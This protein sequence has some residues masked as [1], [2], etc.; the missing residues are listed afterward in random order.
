VFLAFLQIQISAALLAF[1][2][3]PRMAVRPVDP[4]P[5]PSPHR[6]LHV[7]VAPAVQLEVLDWGG[8]GKPLIF[9]AGGGEAG[10]VYDGFAPRFAGRYRV[11]G[12]TRRGVGAST[13]PSAG[14]DTTTLVHDII[15][16][17]DSLHIPRASFAGHSFAGSELN[18]LGV[19]FPQRVDKLVYLD[20]GFPSRGVFDSP[21]WKSGALQTP[22]PP[23]ASYENNSLSTWILW[24]ERI[25]GPG[26]PEAD[27]RA[28]Y[29][30]GPEGEFIGSSSI[31]S[32]LQRLDRGTESVDLRRI[33]AHILAIYAVPGSAEVAYP[34]WQTLDATARA[35]GQ[36]AFTALS[37]LHTRLREQF[38]A[39][40]P[41][42][43]AVIIPGARHY[44]FLTDTG[45]VIH[46]MLE[47]LG[48]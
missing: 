3:E 29:D 6:V 11:L 32:L 22:Q 19:R 14:Y 7:T 16:V 42:V 39:Q 1:T 30:F 44:I 31:D 38:V 40:V 36:K 21:E 17:L 48:S 45:E 26:F 35:R 25:S 23:E 10:H 4:W 8:S 2:P 34:W 47:F 12:I 41:R 20:S 46:S 33:Q 9:L 13:H 5:D 18:A 28:L 37:S 43:R 27:V 15:A 24:A